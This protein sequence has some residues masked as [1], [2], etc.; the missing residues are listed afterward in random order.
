MFIL[1]YNWMMMMMMMMMR[2]DWA[3]DSTDLWSRKE[4]QWAR[5]CAYSPILD[6]YRRPQ[7][8]HGKSEVLRL[9]PAFRSVRLVLSDEI[10]FVLNWEIESRQH[11]RHSVLFEAEDSRSFGAIL[12]RFIL[13]FKESYNVSA[14]L[15]ENVLHLQAHC[16][17][18]SCGTLPRWCIPGVWCN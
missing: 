3:V 7:I 13:F 15:R 6:P 9:V 18:S 14:D 2:M 5:Q 11:E 1:Q 10:R 4:F 8:S 17:R 16:R 12:Q